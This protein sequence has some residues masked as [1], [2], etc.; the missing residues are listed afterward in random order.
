M[1]HFCEV[2][3]TTV[4]SNGSILEMPLKSEMTLLNAINLHQNFNDATKAFLIGEILIVTEALMDAKII[5]ADIKP[6][7]FILVPTRY[8]T[9]KA[10]SK[11]IFC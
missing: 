2:S 9:E 7:N 11:F 10:F 4:F 8:V 3:R 6:D 5:H 1:E